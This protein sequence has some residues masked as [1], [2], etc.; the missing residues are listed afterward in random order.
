LTVL[1]AAPR[2]PGRLYKPL[3]SHHDATRGAAAATDSLSRA[4]QSM[5]MG[6]P[7]LSRYDLVRSRHSAW[8]HGGMLP[9]LSRQE[10]SECRGIV[11]RQDMAMPGKLVHFDQ[12]T[13][14]ALDLLAKDSMLVSRS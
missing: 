9:L 3:R 5:K 6:N 11:T 13:W 14:N 8:W 10:L 4:P 7:P 2:D 12:E 1:A